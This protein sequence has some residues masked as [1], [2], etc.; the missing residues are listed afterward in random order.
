MLPRT[1]TADMPPEQAVI[2]SDREGS[3]V[4][5]RVNDVSAGF[6]PVQILRS[7][8]VDVPAG[9]TLVILG[10]SGC[11]KT[12]LL[13]LLAG[14]LTL[15]EG[16]IWLDGTRISHLAPARRTVIYLDQEPLLFEHLSVRDNVGF[17]MRLRKRPTGEINA[18][19]DEILAAIDLTGH[20][21]KQEWQLSGGQKQRVAFARAVLAR[22]QLL[23]LDE[24]F[25]SL[26]SKT[27]G[28]MQTLFHDL[29]GRFGLTSVFVTHDVK[30]A[31][32][33]G[34]RFSRLSRGVLL[35]YADRQTFINDPATGVPTEIEFWRRSAEF[36]D[37]DC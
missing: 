28:Q 30:E 4:M 26:D 16:E 27:R 8:S 11:G 6:G 5:L 12:T 35:P 20:A 22:P 19:V 1:A 33:V 23:L 13:R 3:S 17:A 37:I 31:L 21:H 9:E 7:V 15:H 29:S 32:V 18:A 10:E 25:C 2:T 14:L 36:L 34:S 24:P